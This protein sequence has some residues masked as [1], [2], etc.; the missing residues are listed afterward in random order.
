MLKKTEPPKIW[1]AMWK[2][3]SYVLLCIFIA[4]YV[5][6]MRHEIDTEEIKDEVTQEFKVF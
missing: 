3:K 5:S 1:D 2:A 4:V 6:N